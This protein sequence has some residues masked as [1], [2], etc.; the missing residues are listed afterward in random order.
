MR[1]GGIHTAVLQHGGKNID[2]FELLH[3]KAFLK[4]VYLI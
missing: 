4:T 1:R 2:K 3:Y